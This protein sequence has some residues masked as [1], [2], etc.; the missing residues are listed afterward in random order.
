MLSLGWRQVFASAAQGSFVW[1]LQHLVGHVGE[2]AD[3]CCSTERAHWTDAASVDS[4]EQEVSG[5]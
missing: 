3:P 5:Y 2:L 1:L 4:A